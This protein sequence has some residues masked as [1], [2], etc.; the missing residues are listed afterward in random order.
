VRRGLAGALASLAVS[1]AANEPPAESPDSVFIPP[2]RRLARALRIVVPDYPK[3]ALA[4]RVQGVVDIRGR[5]ATNGQMTDPTFTP[6][7]PGAEVF[8]PAL[9]DV[10]YGWTFDRAVGTDCQPTNEFLA[11]RVHFEIDGEKPRIFVTHSPTTLAAK[12]E[13]RP[14]SPPASAGRLAELLKAPDYKAVTRVEPKYPGPLLRQGVQAYVFV[15]VGIDPAGRVVDVRGKA[16]VTLPQVA[17]VQKDAYLAERMQRAVAFLNRVNLGPFEEATDV[18]LRQ[19]TF[20]SIGLPV[21]RWMCLDFV[22]RI[23]D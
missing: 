23:K 7:S 2:E 16:H 22:Y 21:T 6:G 13:W 8:I 10:L 1:A 15:L 5:V 20:P 4:D 14:N 3:A 9:Q 17:R 19:W 11:F 12:S 18:A